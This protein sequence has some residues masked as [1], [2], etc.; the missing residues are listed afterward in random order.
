MNTPLDLALSYAANGWPVFPCRHEEDYDRSTGE[1]LPE[2]APLISNGF[3]GATTTE[4]II[5]ALWGNHPHAAIGIPTGE[6]IGA[7]VLDLDVKPSANG[8]DW[9]AEQEEKHGAL[10]TSARVKTANGGTHIFF[11]HVEGVRNRGKLGKGVDVRGEGGFVVAP[12][13][14]LS[15]RREYQWVEG[16]GPTTIEDAPQWLLDL[17]LPPKYE[18]T[19]GEWSYTPGTN[20]RYIMRAVQLELDCLA[21]T[22]PGRRGEQLNMSAFALGQLVGAGALDRSEAEHGLFAAAVTCGLLQKDGERSVTTTIRR[23]LDAGIKQPRN[24]PERE[25]RQEDNTSLE[26]INA[27]IERALA[28]ESAKREEQV[29]VQPK[30]PADDSSE[31]VLATDESPQPAAPPESVFPATPFTWLDPKTIP[32]RQFAFGTHYIR[33]YVSVTVSPGGIGKTSNSIAESLAMT[34]GKALTGT[35]PS[36]RLNVWVFNAEDPLDEME[37]RIMAACLHFN[38]KPSDIEGRLFLDTGRERELVIMHEDKKTGLTI[39]EPVVGAVVEQIQRNKIDVMIIDPFV[40][41][42]RVNENDNG[43]IDKV[44]KLWAQIADRTNCAVDVVHHLKKMADKEATV[45][46]ARG[47][48]SLIGAARSVRVLNRMTEEQETK[49]GLERDD[50]FSYFWI[51]HGKSN[52]TKMDNSQHWRRL[53]SVPLGNGGDG[54]MSFMV[55]DYVGVVT[56]W[57]WPSKDEIAATVDDGVQRDVLNKLAN[58]NHRES[59][60]SDQWAGYVLAEAMNEPIDTGRAMTPA[61][62]KVKAVLDSW[63][64]SGILMVSRE[65]DPAHIGRTVKY[66]RPASATT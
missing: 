20:D 47:A 34:S 40:S 23:G 4:R 52:L 65:P 49:A 13:S 26:H 57:K 64:A 3:R 18:H 60:Q 10:P 33:K 15:G 8:H 39:N 62:R 35:K 2:K 38:L 9:L 1:V 28:K 54:D 46:D 53:E 14:A 5:R 66:I 59:P 24:I 51:S 37:R 43:A 42:H 21:G 6:K 29:L 25:H 50:R 63:I 61:K 16:T 12:G 31:A 41:T 55:Q 11:K 44:A 30:S 36:E 7:W 56:E 27:M 22:Y 19:P 58:Q 32:I 45:E 17:V 48:V